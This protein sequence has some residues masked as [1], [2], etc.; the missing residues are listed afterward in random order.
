M[1]RRLYE[2]NLDPIGTRSPQR[3]GTP[4]SHGKPAEGRGTS[5]QKHV[6]GTAFGVG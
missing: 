2:G 5:M 6:C 1:I 3:I 4:R